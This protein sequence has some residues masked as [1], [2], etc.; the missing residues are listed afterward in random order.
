MF[1]ITEAQRI[2]LRNVRALRGEHIEIAPTAAIDDVLRVHLDHAAVDIRPNG[3]C[4][5]VH[6][7]KQRSRHEG[8]VAEI[9]RPFDALAGV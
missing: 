4:S 3:E 9:M 6:Y 1:E 2:T 5:L 7:G 8:T